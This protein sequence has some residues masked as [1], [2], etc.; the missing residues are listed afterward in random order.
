MNAFELVD[1]QVEVELVDHLA[2]L[3]RIAIDVA[4]QTSSQRLRRI[5]QFL[6]SLRM[7]VVDR[8]ARDLAQQ[9][10][11]APDEVRVVADVRHARRTLTNTARRRL[12]TR[13]AAR[14]FRQATYYVVRRMTLSHDEPLP[15][16]WH[17]W[18]IGA[19]KDSPATARASQR[20]T[21][22][23][24]NPSASAALTR[25]F[26][27]DALDQEHS[28]YI[29]MVDGEVGAFVSL[30]SSS[31]ALRNRDAR[32]VGMSDKAHVPATHL[33]YVARADGS[34]YRDL[35]RKA[36]LYAASIARR[37]NQFQRTAV[38]VVDPYDDETE[39]MWRT[40]FKFWSTNERC[41]NGCRRLYHPIPPAPS[42]NDSH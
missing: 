40:S 20:F 7:R 17:Q 34:K 31:V 38:L 2:R 19:A 32:K 11:N 29:L 35:G 16:G 28:V 10:G 42:T 39:E 41:T 30:R 27:E 13:H 23:A 3:R 14:E 8:R 21:A 26:R 6:Q 18:T 33:A 9:L 15:N 24:A 36:V 5:E 1:L 4:P 37:I 22:H 25:W 12:S